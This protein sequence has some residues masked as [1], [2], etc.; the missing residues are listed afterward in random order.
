MS[1][2]RVPYNLLDNPEIQENF[3]FLEELLTTF[4][5]EA[6]AKLNSVAIARRKA[7]QKIPSGAF[8]LVA[9]DEVIND[10]GSNMNVGGYYVV[11]STGY[12]QVF[13]NVLI[14]LG[15][16]AEFLLTNQISV[17]GVPVQ[18][19]IYGAKPIVAQEFAGVNASGIMFCK[20][21]ERIEYQVFQNSGAEIELFT[22]L[23][24]YNRLS[25]SR[26]A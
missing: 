23:P 12:Y 11:P 1:N 17:S 7:I 10:P 4:S 13:G 16:T 3:E 22:T 25:V 14:K 2:V 9:M 20:A 21:G 19:G 8:T 6:E 24:Q 5:N 26:I 15:A 18:S